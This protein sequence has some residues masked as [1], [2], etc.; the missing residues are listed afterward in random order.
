MVAGKRTTCLIMR[1]R[2]ALQSGAFAAALTLAQQAL[3]SAGQ[4][5]S[6][7]PLKDGHMVA[8]IHR[9][10]GDIR[11]SMGDNVGAQA[12][13]STALSSLPP[14]AAETPSE[15]DEHATIL[16]RLGRRAEALQ[17][18]RRLNSMGYRRIT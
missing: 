9:L 13:W 12:E 15:M 17:L 5:H 7:D 4:V 3:Q 2:L 8:S 11:R 18:G 14:N 6:E 16:D 1:S 10:A